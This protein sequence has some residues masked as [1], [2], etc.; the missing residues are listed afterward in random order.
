MREAA[1][2][3]PRSGN[4]EGEEVLQVSNY[5][6][7][8]QVIRQTMVRQM[9]P[10][11]HWGPQWSRYQYQPATPGEPHGGAGRYALQEAAAFKV[12][13]QEQ[14]PNKTCSSLTEAHTGAGFLAKPAEQPMLKLM[15]GC[16]FHGWDPTPKQWKSMRKRQ[17]W[18]ALSWL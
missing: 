5:K 3:T 1:L 17:T 12:P 9:C 8:L 2:Q 7:P 13:T 16:I 10:C 4:E 14:M 11:S 15:K 18:R 6:V